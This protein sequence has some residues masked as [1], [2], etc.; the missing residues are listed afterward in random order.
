MVADRQLHQARVPTG[1]LLLIAGIFLALGILGVT[2]KVRQTTHSTARHGVEVGQIHDCLEE[3][4]P[5]LTWQ[6]KSPKRPNVFYL[7]CEVEPDDWGLMIAERTSKGWREITT[8]RP[9]GGTWA[10]LWEYMTARGNWVP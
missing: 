9:K 1:I 2:N 5:D 8:F 10:E 3:R 4:G 6:N 7:A